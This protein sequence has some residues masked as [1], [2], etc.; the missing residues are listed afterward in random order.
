[1]RK[2]SLLITSTSLHQ[3][4]PNALISGRGWRGEQ[5]TVRL[6]DLQTQAQAPLFS[7]TVLSLSNPDATG[8]RKLLLQVLREMSDGHRENCLSLMT[9]RQLRSGYRGSEPLQGACPFCL[10]FC[11]FNTGPAFSP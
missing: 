9:R 10:G 5:V 2:E 8:A 11:L 7:W 3:Y 6:W 4:S 1:M